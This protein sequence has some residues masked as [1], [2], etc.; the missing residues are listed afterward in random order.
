MQQPPP[1]PVT[2][3]D[4][5]Y[6]FDINDELYIYLRRHLES[7]VDIF[8]LLYRDS[9]EQISK[10]HNQS[11]AGDAGLGSPVIHGPTIPVLQ[12]DIP[13]STNEVYLNQISLKSRELLNQIRYLIPLPIYRKCEQDVLAVRDYFWKTLIPAI[14]DGRNVMELPPN[15]KGELEN[16]LLRELEQQWI[17]YLISQMVDKLELHLPLLENEAACVKLQSAQINPAACVSLPENTLLVCENVQRDEIK[18]IGFSK[19]NTCF[20]IYVELRGSGRKVLAHIANSTEITPLIN[21]I[22]ESFADCLGQ[23]KIFDM[24]IMGGQRSDNSSAVKTDSSTYFLGVFLVQFMSSVRERQLSLNLQSMNCFHSLQSFKEYNEKKSREIGVGSLFDRN[25]HPLLIHYPGIGYQP[26]TNLGEA[27]IVDEPGKRFYVWSRLMLFMQYREAEVVEIYNDSD[28]RFNKQFIA[29]ADQQLRVAFI[30]RLMAELKNKGILENN[31][32]N[33]IINL[34]N[35]NIDQWENCFSL[36]LK[37]RSHSISWHLINFL[38][39]NCNKRDIE[40]YQRENISITH[41]AENLKETHIEKTFYIYLLNDGCIRMAIQE[42]AFNWCVSVLVGRDPRL[43]AAAL[44]DCLIRSNISALHLIDA[45]KQFQYAAAHDEEV[46]RNLL[47][48]I[49][50]NPNHIEQ[51]IQDWQKETLLREVE[52][53]II[54]RLLGSVKMIDMSVV[55]YLR[56]VLLSHGVAILPYIHKDILTDPPINKLFVSL[57]SIINRPKWIK[58]STL[59]LNKEIEATVSNFLEKVRIIP[60]ESRIEKTRLHLSNK[61]GIIARTQ[62]TSPSPRKW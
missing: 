29:N 22:Y 40:T 9:M 33:F 6:Q 61:D 44:A 62:A 3:R 46:N 38:N 18:Y 32:D 2:V 39:I 15:F 23:C 11:I 12:N 45:I 57:V 49:L 13:I 48:R 47:G 43:N 51:I 54:N 52:E 5:A 28:P 41:L 21:K 36:L 60:V 24:R 56:S 10:H 37:T 30:Q 26:Y 53:K 58:E 34:I 20:G 1:V 35:K 31:N 19:V 27:V 17:Y 8:K 4:I 16:R 14:I 55:A 59:E 42:N 50:S 25:G 7:L